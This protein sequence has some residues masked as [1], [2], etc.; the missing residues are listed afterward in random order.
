MLKDLGVCD[1]LKMVDC[2]V[3][4]LLPKTLSCCYIVVGVSFRSVAENAIVLLSFRSVG[5]EN[6]VVLLPFHSVAAFH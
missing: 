6:A 2:C 5:A 1:Q 3:V 4:A